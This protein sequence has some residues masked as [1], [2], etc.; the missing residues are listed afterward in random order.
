MRRIHGKIFEIIP[1][2]YMLPA[3]WGPFQQ[4]VKRSPG[5]LWIRKPVASSRGRGVRVVA[6]P[7]AISQKCKKVIIQQY[8]H[9][10]LCI[11]GYKFDLRVY[12][13][14]TSFHPLRAYL[15]QNAL[16]RFASVKYDRS[17]TSLKNRQIHLTNHTIN[18]KSNNG[19]H[20]IKWPINTLWDHLKLQGKEEYC[21]V[22]WTQVQ[23]LC[24]LALLAAHSR[25]TSQVQRT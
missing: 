17:K 11:N 20:P 25:M 9:R 1:L 18:H 15:Y 8:V 6:D 21:D 7:A 24:A 23:Q 16:V 14:V 3:E 22:I 2:F 10:P 19:V 12:L 4:H 5:S 13:A